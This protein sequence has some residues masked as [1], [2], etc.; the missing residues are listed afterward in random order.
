MQYR[1]LTNL[2]TTE[3]RQ[4]DG[5]QFTTIAMV[6]QNPFT[7]EF[8]V[9]NEFLNPGTSYQFR[10]GFPF[11][12]YTFYSN[13][14]IAKTFDSNSPLVSYLTTS[15]T[16]SSI[17]ASWEVPEYTNGIIGYRAR[18]YVSAYDN[19]GIENPTFDSS[20]ATIVQS[21]DLSLSETSFTFGCSGNDTKNCLHPYTMYYIEIGVVHDGSGDSIKSF[22][23]ATQVYVAPIVLRDAAVM[24]LHGQTITV[25]LLN[26]VPAYG[27]PTGIE[28]TFLY[29]A[30]LTSADGA[31]NMAL[32][33]SSVVSESD[34]TVKITMT[35]AEYSLLVSSM[36]SKSAFSTLFLKYG[37]SG[38]KIQLSYYCLHRDPIVLN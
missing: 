9:L 11:P 31:I 38:K 28:S 13:T 15:S 34:L 36:Y 18:I 22:Y 20:T 5:A 10:L 25:T 8:T 16:S 30:M 6:F 19:G 26:P 14:L 29:P 23:V 24:F 17:H 37:S 32:S 21:A 2:T 27:T 33:D 12:S 3:T 4:D 7:L 35:V 1:E